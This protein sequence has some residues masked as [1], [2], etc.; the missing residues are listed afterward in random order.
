MPNDHL[1]AASVEPPADERTPEQLLRIIFDYTA[2]IANEKS[3]SNVLLH[4]ADMGREMILADRCTVW[5]IDRRSRELFTTVAHGVDEIRIPL[6]TGFAGYAIETGE[7]ILIEDAYNDPRHNAANDQKTGYHTKSLI[8]V[9]FV[10]ND[11]SI[12]GAYQAVNKRSASSVFTNRDLE[13]LT[14]AASYAGK[15]L[16]SVMLHEEIAATQRD[17]IVAM[18]EIG[19]SRS[20]ETGNHVKRVA[21][22]SYILAIGCG[23]SHEEAEQL[24]IASPMHDIGKVAIPDAILQKP[25]KLTEEEFEIMKQHTLIGYSM[26]KSSGR[27]LL[28]IAATIALQH[29]EKWNGAGYPHGLSGEDIHLYGRITAIADVFDALGSDRVYKKAWELDRILA[30]MQ[31]ERGRHFDPALIDVFFE[32]L[33]KL[34]TIREQYQ[35]KLISP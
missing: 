10:G 17:L 26:L 34:L 30:L 31:E 21:E 15:S 3:L 7:P 35:D 11:G 24:K 12:L 2:K 6:G 20:K 25:G 16:E 18:G 1:T 33:P 13:H 14:L 9:P 32:Q 29:H 27:A 8:T 28:N 4:M 22:Y 19:E 5:L 23:L